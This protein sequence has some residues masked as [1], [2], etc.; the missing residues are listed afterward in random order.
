MALKLTGS[1]EGYRAVNIPEVL[2]AEVDKLV[3]RKVL[4]NC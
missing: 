1:R 4:R 3:E 2:L